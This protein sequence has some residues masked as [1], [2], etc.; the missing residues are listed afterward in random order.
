M[1]RTSTLT[2]SLAEVWSLYPSLHMHNLH[3]NQHSFGSPLV[4]WCSW[5]L[6]DC[7]CLDRKRK[8]DESGWR[9][10]IFRP[11]SKNFRQAFLPISGLMSSCSVWHSSSFLC[12]LANS[13]RITSRLLLS[14]LSNWFTMRVMLRIWEQTCKSKWYFIFQLWRK[15]G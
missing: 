4:C 14:K 6:C 15:P 8:N 9:Y 13:M 1:H 2:Q 7:S 3:S 5:F 10:L 11:L 12:S